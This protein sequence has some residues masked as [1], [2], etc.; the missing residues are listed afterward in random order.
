IAYHKNSTII[1]C[2]TEGLMS[3]EESGSLFDN[4][5]I[6]MAILSSNLVIINHKGELSSNVEDLIGM[7]LYAKIQIGGTPVKSKL[8]F[9]LRDQTNRD[10]KIFSQQLNKLKDNLQEKGSFLK[11]SIDEELDIKSDNIRLLPSAF[12][13]DI[14]PDYNIEQRWRTQTFPIEINNLRT[15]I[16]L[17]LDE[18]IQQQSQQKCLCKTFDYLYNKL[19]NNW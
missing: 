16:F 17:S 8:L 18:Q 3:L 4:Q 13:E 5:M 11:V 6:T 12:T 2:D 10:L 7:S 14:N 1:I 15:N 19:T 9:V